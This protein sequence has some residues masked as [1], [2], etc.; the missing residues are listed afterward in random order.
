MKSFKGLS[1]LRLKKV[2]ELIYAQLGKWV[3]I[4]KVGRIRYSRTLIG[5]IFN[6]KHIDFL[7]FCY[8]VMADTFKVKASTDY[9]ID[10]LIDICYSKFILKE[11]SLAEIGAD[12]KFYTI[13]NI[14]RNSFQ[15]REYLINH[16]SHKLSLPVV[17]FLKKEFAD[18]DYL[19]IAMP[20]TV[21]LIARVRK[22][23]SGI[24]DHVRKEFNLVRAGPSYTRSPLTLVA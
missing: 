4:N 11:Y 20:L 13:R 7:E 22:L 5:F 8:T 24:I 1:R 19:N 6:P 2:N 18:R 14:F 16:Y 10:Q 23:E 9:T 3:F 21:T 17:T 12:Y 15:S